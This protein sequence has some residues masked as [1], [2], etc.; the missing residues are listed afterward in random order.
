VEE[1]RGDI[2]AAIAQAEQSQQLD[3]ALTLRIFRLAL[4]EARLAHQTGD[5]GLAAAAIEH[6][7]VGLEQEPILGLNSANLAGLL[8]QQARPAE[9]IELMQRTVAAE[10]DS[11]YLVNLGYFYEQLGD[12]AEAGAAYGRALAQA[13][14]LAGSGFWQA[15]A[16]RAA[17]WPEIAEAA[18]RSAGDSAQAR[19]T[20]ELELALAREEFDAVEKIIGPVTSEIATR[21][22]YNLAEVYLHRA[23]PERAAALL[24][25]TPRTGPEYLLWGR[26]KLQQGGE[27]EAEK[28]LKTAAFLGTGQAHYYLGQLYEQQGR[29][30]AAEQAYQRGF[31]PRATSENVEVTIYGRRAG[32]DMAPQLLRIGISPAAAAPWLALARLQEAQGE[33]DRARYI[34]QF[35]LAEDPF[36][37][38]AQERLARLK[39]AAAGSQ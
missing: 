30:Q 10:A 13:P 31:S 21:S 33:L 16:E 14:A 9:A 25:P 2:R 23:Q 5:S 19:R 32:N 7:Q 15:D 12:W 1:G 3:P 38:I 27:V 35:L 26:I 18:A 20:V 28:L 17:R 24:D 6:Y 4:L 37:S 34:Y 8:W 22:G 36:L 29:L 11:L 39:G